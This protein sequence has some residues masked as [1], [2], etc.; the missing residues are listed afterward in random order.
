MIGAP[1]GRLLVGGGSHQQPV[2]ALELPAVFHEVDGKII[3][4]CRMCRRIPDLTEIAG[5]ID[6]IYPKTNTNLYKEICEKGLIISEI[7]LLYF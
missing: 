5:G 2:Q 3:E 7:I 6:N 4:Q 1:D